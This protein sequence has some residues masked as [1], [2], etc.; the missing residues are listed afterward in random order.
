MRIRIVLAALL[1]SSAGLIAQA[2]PAPP[3]TDDDALKAK[4]RE[5]EVVRERIAQHQK[6]VQ[7]DAIQGTSASAKEAVDALTT[8]GV[9]ITLTFDPASNPDTKTF[10]PAIFS[11][12]VIGPSSETHLSGQTVVFTAKEV[13]GYQAK[14]H[15]TSADGHTQ[16]DVRARH[17]TVNAPVDWEQ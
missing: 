16:A 14:L 4:Q 3:P 5:V 8:T 17:F 9:K 7:A 13:G 15:V 2:T 10:T 12:T 6:Q 1:L 11:W